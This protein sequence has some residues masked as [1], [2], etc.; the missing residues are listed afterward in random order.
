MP[1][2][3][4]YVFD[5]GAVFK[6]MG[7]KAVPAGMRGYTSCNA[8]LFSTFLKELVDTVWTQVIPCSAV[9]EQ[10]IPRPAAFKPVFGQDIQSPIRQNR[11]T[12]T[13]AFCIPDMNGF[14]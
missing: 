13:A 10:D 9:W 14:P 2:K 1:Q 4:L 5:A 12:V 3:N 11:I 7:R 8:C 6:K